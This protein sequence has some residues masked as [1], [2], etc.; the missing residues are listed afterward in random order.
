MT[1]PKN[2]Q[3]ASIASAVSTSESALMA[4]ASSRDG[5]ANPVR[6]SPTPT[7]GANGVIAAVAEPTQGAPSSAPRPSTSAM[8]QSGAQSTDEMVLSASSE[9]PVLGAAPSAETAQIS[10]SLVDPAAQHGVAKV[11]SVVAPGPADAHPFAAA[12]VAD[13][14]LARPAVVQAQT[15][16]ESSKQAHETLLDWR[17]ARTQQWLRQVPKSRYSIQLLATEASQRRNLEAFLARRE[18]AGHIQQIF[19]FATQINARE[20]FSVLFGEFATYT[21]AVDAL[22][23][24]P[25]ELLQRKPFIRNVKDFNALG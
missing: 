11:D 23:E 13:Q 21:Q 18:R 24:L 14:A 22:R 7:A 20:W 10:G 4:G 3:S 25:A 16:T 6:A 5:R 12:R 9:A 15:A 1:V 17:L 8:L 2:M 19:V